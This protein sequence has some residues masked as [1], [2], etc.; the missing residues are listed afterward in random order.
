[1]QF[2]IKQCNIAPNNVIFTDPVKLFFL[3]TIAFFF[4]FVLYVPGVRKSPRKSVCEPQQVVGG[5][6]GNYLT[7]FKVNI[8]T[9]TQAL[10]IFS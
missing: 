1:M 6:S 10:F 4:N 2:I 3:F 8:D 5:K 7:E 9:E